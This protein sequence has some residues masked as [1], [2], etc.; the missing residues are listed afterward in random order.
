MIPKHAQQ[1]I[2]DLALDDCTPLFDIANIVKA[3]RPDCASDELIKAAIQFVR[4]LL[5]RG[6]A[7]LYYDCLEQSSE[8]YR[9]IVELTPEQVHSELQDLSNWQFHERRPP[10]LR[11]VTLVATAAALDALYAGEFRGN[12]A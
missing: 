10:D 6:Y 9:H 12:S 1:E 5:S 2:L 3:H 8:N 11:W 7:K 4:V